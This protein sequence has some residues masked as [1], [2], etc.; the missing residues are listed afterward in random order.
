MKIGTFKTA[1]AAVAIVVGTTV[2]AGA[3][4]INF[5][6]FAADNAN[7]PMP[8]GRYAAMGVTFNATDDGTTWSGLSAGDPGNWDIEGTNGTTFMGFNGTSYGLEMVF[9][10]L[11]SAFS[12]DASRSLGSS[13]GESLT[14]SG[15]NGATLVDSVN[16]VFGAINDWSTFAL[17]GDINRVVLAGSQISSFSPYGVDNINWRDVAPIPVPAAGLMLAG[18][19]GGL[20]F[21]ARRRK[22]AV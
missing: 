13:S 1:V 17:T 5:E 14:V 2:G 16:L 10:S 6:E 12:L 20:G 7:G 9:A 11:V 22:R 19:L 8:A 4:T 15:Y 18:A 3:G 21:A